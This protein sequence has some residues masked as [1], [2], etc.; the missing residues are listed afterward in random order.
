MNWAISLVLHTKAY[1]CLCNRGN[2]F[3]VK[4]KSGVEISIIPCDLCYD[5]TFL[6]SS[7]P[8]KPVC[9]VLSPQTSG[10]QD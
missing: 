1:H 7:M 3:V 9:S 5:V 4:T 2:H 8:Q 6:N 10:L